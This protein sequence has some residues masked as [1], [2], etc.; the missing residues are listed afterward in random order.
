MAK[1]PLEFDFEDMSIEEA[2]AATAVTRTKV[3]QWRKCD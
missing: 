3:S 2:K 1:A